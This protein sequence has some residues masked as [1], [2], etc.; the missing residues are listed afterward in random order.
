M[1]PSEPQQRLGTVAAIDD[2]KIARLVSVLKDLGQVAVAYSGGVD[3]AFLL[4]VAW[5]VLGQGAMGVLAWSESMDRNEYAEAQKVAAAMGIPIRIIETREFDNPAYRQNAPDRCYHCKTELFKRVKDFA[6]QKGIPWVLDGSNSDDLGDYRPGARAR[7]EKGVRSPLQEAGLT[8]DE[9][10]RHSRALG[11]PTWDKPSAPCLSSR[12]PYGT[13][14]TDERLRQVEASEASLR[15]L[16]F[17]EVRVRHHGQIA[18][19]EIPPAD[20]PRILDA[21]VREAVI[22][23]I[24]ESGFLYVA[25]DLQGIRSGS[26]NEVLKRAGASPA[27]LDPR[28]LP[29]IP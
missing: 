15:S 5:D 1:S 23:A 22:G 6:A 10:R 8:K 4:K 13:E 16:G 24:K 17:R 20:F 26:L 7:A 27:P 14:V 12:I 21:Q 11:V 19:I 28:D 25:L 2:P 3:S 9:I 18:R 29:I